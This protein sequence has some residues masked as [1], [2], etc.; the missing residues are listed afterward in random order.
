MI[1]ILTLE[2][3]KELLNKLE[4]SCNL[5][6]YSAG[7]LHIVNILHDDE[8]LS[9]DALR[10]ITSM[11]RYLFTDLVIVTLTQ[12]NIQVAKYLQSIE[13]KRSAFAAGVYSYL[14]P[15]RPVN[16]YNRIKLLVENNFIVVNKYNS[17][18]EMFVNSCCRREQIDSLT[19]LIKKGYK[20][21]N[22]NIDC[23]KQKIPSS[24]KINSL[25]DTYFNK[26]KSK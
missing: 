19:Y 22:K 11:K 24:P 23:L 15:D 3:R 9:K 17:N 4:E 5:P 13:I 10:I 20:F 26:R 16:S 7:F 12:E 2:D 6:T 8:D 18:L 1:N 25:Y 14:Q 21:T